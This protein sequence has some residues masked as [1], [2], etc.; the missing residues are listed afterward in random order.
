M[1]GKK[2]GIVKAA[3]E[4]QQGRRELS[5]G[6][7]QR[8]ASKRQRE[9]VKDKSKYR[10]EGRQKWRR[11]TEVWRQRSERKEAEMWSCAPE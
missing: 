7:R 9:I 10:T 11:V 3:G 2:E 6:G 5:G 1:L 8:A 4:R